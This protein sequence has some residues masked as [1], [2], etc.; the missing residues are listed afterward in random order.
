MIATKIKI[1][2][3]NLIYNYDEYEDILDVYTC[4]PEPVISDEISS[5][6][7]CYYSRKTDE[8][9]GVSIMNYTLRDRKHINDILPFNISFTV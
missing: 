3:E 7:Y 2:Q 5:G 6:I 8:L 4:I 9:I 1:P